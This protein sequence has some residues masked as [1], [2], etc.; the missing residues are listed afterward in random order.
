DAEDG[1]ADARRQVRRVE[2]RAVPAH[3]HH[4]VE[5]PLGTGGWRPAV[6]QQV[7]LHPSLP[8]P[9]DERLG[10]A[11]RART[12]GVDDEPNAAH[13]R[14]PSA[15]RPLGDRALTPALRS[16]MPPRP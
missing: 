5:A 16:G 3:R 2:E 10:S 15:P 1:A 14:P 12:T 11:R 6:A 8:E 13:A 7:D 9:G 4:E